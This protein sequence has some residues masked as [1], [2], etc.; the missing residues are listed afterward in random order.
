[1][2]PRAQENSDQIETEEIPNNPNEA[3]SETEDGSPQEVREADSEEPEV[4]SGPEVT[5]REH[6]GVDVG[7][8]RPRIIS[9]A[10]ISL[11]LLFFSVF[12]YLLIQFIHFVLPSVTPTYWVIL[13][14]LLCSK[15]FFYFLFRTDF[16]NELLVN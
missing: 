9:T 6:H 5:Y 16:G 14:P 1:M 15:P 13:V 4:G 8:K 11:K 12:M 3:L 7:D 10:Q 2:A